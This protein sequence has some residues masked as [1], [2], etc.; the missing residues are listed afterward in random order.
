MCGNLSAMSHSYDKHTANAWPWGSKCPEWHALIRLGSSVT[1]VAM[2]H[3]TRGAYCGQT[4][5]STIELSTI[6]SDNRDIMR[7]PG[8]A[9]AWL[10]PHFLLHSFLPSWKDKNQNPYLM[11]GFIQLHVWLWSLHLWG[12]CIVICRPTFSC[13]SFP[14]HCYGTN[15]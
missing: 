1:Y 5:A 14:T 11:D 6:Q 10:A 13:H 15:S 12:C 8:F 2:M 3:F 9:V 4:E 7:L